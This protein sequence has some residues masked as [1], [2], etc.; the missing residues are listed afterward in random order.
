M[1]AYIDSISLHV[2]DLKKSVD[3]YTNSFDMKVIEMT[4]NC[5]KIGFDE[6]ISSQGVKI[7]LVEKK[8][9]KRG[10]VRM[11]FYL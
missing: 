3:F 5:A 4:A 8:G 11:T 7:D 6:S 2:D 1:K 9:T 10:D